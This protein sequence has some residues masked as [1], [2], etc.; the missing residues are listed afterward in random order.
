MCRQY[1]Q[2]GKCIYLTWDNLAVVGWG[3]ERKNMDELFVDPNQMVRDAIVTALRPYARLASSGWA[4]YPT[5]DFDDLDAQ[6]RMV[7]VLLGR[8]ASNLAGKVES[9]RLSKE[10]L[11]ALAAVGDGTYR[12]YAPRLER[13]GLIRR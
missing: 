4:F 5:P 2:F 11:C 8:K 6:Q 12:P 13:A 3:A 9:D 10:E 7:V 1:S